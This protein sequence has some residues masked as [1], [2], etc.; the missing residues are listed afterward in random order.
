MSYS[1]CQ[2]ATIYLCTFCFALFFWS[3]PPAHFFLC[4]ALLFCSFELN[5]TDN[6]KNQ[7]EGN[8]GLPLIRRAFRR[9]QRRA[10]RY[11]WSREQLDPNTS[12]PCK[13]KEAKPTPVNIVLLLK[14]PINVFYLSGF[15]LYLILL[16]SIDTIYQNLFFSFY[17]FFDL[18]SLFQS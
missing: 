11:L 5:D 2:V 8:T 15:F 18:H 3:F 7:A 14:K 16:P 4:F 12:C 1:M 10:F 6:N 9:K 17:S 13:E